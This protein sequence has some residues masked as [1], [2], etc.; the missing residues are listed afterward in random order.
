MEVGACA[1]GDAVVV[2]L[3]GV[4]DVCTGLAAE[5]LEGKMLRI[6]LGSN[7][8]SWRDGIER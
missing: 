2:R 1:V 3:C 7:W 4:D 8:V 5:D 6:A